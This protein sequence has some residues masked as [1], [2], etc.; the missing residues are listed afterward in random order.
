MNLCVLADAASVHTQR[1]ARF[2][3]EKGHN[4][5]VL[6]FRP[7]EIKNVTVHRL[8]PIFPGKIGYTTALPQVR[9]YIRV[10]RPDILHAHYATSFGLLGAMS[11]F[12]PYIVSVW[13]SDVYDFPRKSPFHRKLL[14][15]NLSLADYVCSTS[16]IMASETS[17]YCARE[18]TVTPFG[19]DCDSFRPLS[20]NECDSDEFI[21]G[22]VRWLDEKY[23]I[24]FL[25]RSFGLLA[26]KY[27]EK[28][29]LK[30]VIGGDGYLKT[31]LVRLVGELGIG[32][33]T[34]F[35]GF[36]P[37]NRMPEILNSFSIFVAVS[38]S[39]GESFGV[40][41]L[42][43]SACGKPV[44]V[45]NVGGL[46]EVVQDGITGVIVPPRDVEA[47]AAAIS[48]FIED[49]QA[50]REMGAAGR[51]FVLKDYEWYENASRMERL[52]HS[53]LCRQ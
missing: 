4:V 16:R 7:A 52:Y 48:K 15:F 36:I 45:S 31:E 39:E 40:A 42:E 11:G 43:A 33:M 3:A 10:R 13:G 5:D 1:W 21:V 27:R 49:E 12:H 14:E 20:R 17:R 35:L 53:I 37:H 51:E 25:I 50:R 34:E 29:K 47:T 44:I 2:F 28:K 19:V 41:V 8:R 22:T 32:E 9:K 6:S 38:I 30:L 26:R 24:E 46:S 18:I 23:G